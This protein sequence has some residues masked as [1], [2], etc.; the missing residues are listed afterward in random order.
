[1]D[2]AAKRV[3]RSRS[4]GTLRAS[5]HVYRQRT[6]HADS[7]GRAPA[8][9][10]LARVGLRHR[11][12][13][14]RLW[15]PCMGG[16]SLPMASPMRSISEWSPQPVAC[17]RSARSR[18]DLLRGPA[19]HGHPR[20]ACGDTKVDA[21]GDEHRR[22]AEIKCRLGHRRPPSMS[23]TFWKGP[24]SGA[25]AGSTHSSTAGRGP[26]SRCVHCCLDRDEGFGVLAGQVPHQLDRLGQHLGIGHGG[27]D[28]PGSEGLGAAVPTAGRHRR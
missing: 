20:P 2:A 22:P 14:P 23:S 3:Y 18:I 5:R 11:I 26:R 21:A 17:A 4:W 7:F 16:P 15:V 25:G 24:S 9:G 19:H 28:Q 8:S 6:R 12:C 10:M 13:R 1:V 27:I